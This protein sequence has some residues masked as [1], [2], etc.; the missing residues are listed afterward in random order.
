[1][2]PHDNGYRAL[3][4][5]CARVRGHVEPSEGGAEHVL[6]GKGCLLSLVSSHSNPLQ[7]V[8]CS[9]RSFILCYLSHPILEGGQSHQASPRARSEA[10]R[11]PW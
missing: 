10:A 6:K 9:P 5:H 8:R 11:G 1:M 4:P 7:Q 3:T 2:L